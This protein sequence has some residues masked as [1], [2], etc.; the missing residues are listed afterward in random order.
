M[1]ISG[2]L[3]SN[4]SLGSLRGGAAGSIE[5]VATATKYVAA[6]NS[7]SLGARIGRLFKKSSIEGDMFGVTI[8]PKPSQ[9]IGAGAEATLS[10]PAKKL[11]VRVLNAF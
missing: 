7:N 5:P 9:Y 6:S 1:N 4:T 3:A 2:S 8:P 11:E 10:G